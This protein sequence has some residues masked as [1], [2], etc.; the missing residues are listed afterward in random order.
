MGTIKGKIA[1]KIFKRLSCI[2]EEAILGKPFLARG[3]LS[4]R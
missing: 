1:I 4:I 2:E 3:I